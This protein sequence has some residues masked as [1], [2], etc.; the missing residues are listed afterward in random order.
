MSNFFYI[1]VNG[2][3]RGPINIQQLNELAASGIV[4]PNTALETDGGL[5]GVAG[6]VPGLNFNKAVP[7]SAQ[8][9]FCTSCGK[10]VSEQAVACMSCGAKPTGHKNFCRKCGAALRPEQVVCT[11]CGASITAG[12][13]GKVKQA[14]QSIRSSLKLVVLTVVVVVV[15]VI[16]YKFIPGFWANMSVSSNFMPASFNVA[17][18]KKAKQGEMVKYKVTAWGDNSVVTYKVIQNDG[19]KVKIEQKVEGRNVLD[20]NELRFGG[21]RPEGLR[22][23]SEVE[24]INLKSQ[25]EFI[26]SLLKVPGISGDKIDV[27]FKREATNRGE[28][29]VAGSRL[30]CVV[31]SYTATATVGNMTVSFKN[32]KEWTSKEIPMG[33]VVKWEW[34]TTV[35]HFGEGGNEK[36]VSIEIMLTDF[37]SIK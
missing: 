6:Q 25:K 37:S 23:R 34:Q 4:T 30:N 17:S 15:A 21:L 19:D 10:P 31:T 13:S 11:R 20:S 8:P 16:L 26:Q 33:G 7:P 29:A 36:S 1:D 24:E 14:V 3:R 28:V 12:Y 5:K 32:I 9:I 2:Q 27:K 22:S 35:P 18:F